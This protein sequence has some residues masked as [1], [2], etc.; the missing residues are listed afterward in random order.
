MDVGKVTRDEWILNTFPEWGN[1]LHEE[2]D[3]TVVKP[4]TFSMWWLGCTGVWVKS[5]GNCNLAVDMWAGRG[6][7]THSTE[8]M[9]AEIHG[10]KFQ[11]H[12]MTGSRELFPNQRCIPVC[13][14]PFAI[15]QVDAL[16]ATHNHRDH[17]D[18]YVTGAILQTFPEALFIG[19]L[20]AERKWL[21]WGVPAERIRRVR[22]GDSIR[23][24]DTVIHVVESF[25]RTVAL[26]APP[27]GDLSGW[28]PTDMDD[29]TVNYVIETPGGTLYHSGDSHFSN[30]YRKHGKEFKIDVALASFGE[31]APGMTDKLTA[32]DVLRMAENLECKVIIP[33]HYETWNC[34]L[35]N[36]YEIMELYRMRCHRLKYTF[37]PYIW[38]LGGKFT[39]PDNKDDLEF[40]YYRG[41]SDSFEREPNIPFKAYL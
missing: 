11:L 2:I 7:I 4:G 38:Q 31:N 41:F 32:S 3:A 21:S 5:E 19:P 35:G 34:M 40:M 13:F 28:C 12:R 14:D 20:F 25:D 17:M 23:I 26:T 33:V 29:R 27:E 37:K 15:T 24:K 36:P 8:N 10:E 1:W 18:P 30:Y 22:P 16:L 6:K 39:Y 9:P